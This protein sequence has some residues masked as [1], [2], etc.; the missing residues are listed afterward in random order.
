MVEML[1]GTHPWP[2]LSDYLYYA[3]KLSHIKDD[4]IPH[5]K[6]DKNV[7]DELKHVLQLAFTVNYD[8]RPTSTQLLKHEFFKMKF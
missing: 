3:L 8:K 2:Y 4:E 5:Y 1:T 7:S 6:L